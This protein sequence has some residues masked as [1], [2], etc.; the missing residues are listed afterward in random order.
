MLVVATLGASFGAACGGDDDDDSSGASTTNAADT[1][2]ATQPA[3]TGTPIKIGFIVD[4]TGPQGPGQGDIGTAVAEAWEKYTNSH[5]G[6]AGHPVEIDIKDTKGDPANGQSTAAA[7]VDDD[8]TIAVLIEDSA[9]ESSFAPTLSEGGLP[10]VGGLGYYPTVWGALPNVF[11]ITTTFPAVVNMQAAAAKNA[12]ATNVGAAVCAEVDSCAAATPILE[13]AV[14]NEGLNY[15]GTVKVAAS[16]SDFT[17][18]CLQFVNSDTDFIQFSASA[19][20]GVRLYDD[21]TQQGFTGDLG[22]SAGTVNATLYDAEG[23]KLAG[24]LNAFPWWTDDAP[25]KQYRDVM[26]AGDVDSKVYGAPTGTAIYATLELFKKAIEAQAASLPDTLTRE[27]VLTAY[28]AVQ[29][30]T[31]DGLLP[32]PMT[33]TAGQPG[34]QV[35]CFWLYTY[36]NGTFDGTL[37][38]TCAEA[39]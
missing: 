36:A 6:V 3:P 20:V 14:K 27:D 9:G 8:S 11:G 17:A 18:E 30:E 39:S 33:F 38:P 5:G 7:M 22:A 37:E 24:G 16:A 25:V 12:G 2:E 31:L 10:V 4:E 1:T 19:S 23:I 28:G 32:Q 13:A 15:T 29:N 35:P 34:P 26:E 21:C